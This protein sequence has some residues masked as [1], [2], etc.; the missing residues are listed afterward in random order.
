MA[1]R[2]D[3]HEAARGR[4]RHVLLE[5][6]VGAEFLTGKHTGCP[7]CGGKDRFR[8]DNK[9]GSGSSICNVCGSRSG[10]DLVMAVR[11]QSFVEAKRWVFQ[12]IGQA[13]I[14]A[15][16][17]RRSND[18]TM[19]RLSKLWMESTRLDGSDPASLYLAK[20]SI[21]FDSYPSQLRVHNRAAYLH[22]NGS[23]THHPALIAKF[24]SQDVKSWTLHTTF[25][26][27]DGRKAD[28]PKP[29]KLA[30]VA[31][32]LGG[33]VR[34]A[35]SAETMGIAEGIETALSASR[36]FDIPVW[37]ALSAGALI[38]WQPPVRTKCILIFGDLDEGFAGQAAAYTL[39]H[40]LAGKGLNVEVRL[41]PDIGSDWN[42]VLV[43]GAW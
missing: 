1:R 20:R 16:R 2:D 42:D 36:L 33:A 38:K 14:E 34:L 13:P 23:I 24:V 22:E 19:Q 25:L 21:A 11:N 43:A 8:W 27:P 28:V 30:P 31:V 9:A 35:A 6:G 32:P 12:Q 40:K 3:I 5:A 26:S 37:S 39:A 41:P 17:A 7:T 4:W 15:P 29:R 10:I 18:R